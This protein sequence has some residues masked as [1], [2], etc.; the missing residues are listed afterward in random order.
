MNKKYLTLLILGVTATVYATTTS[1]LLP[2]SVGTY[3]AWTPSTGSTHYTLVDESSCNGATDYVSTTAVGSRESFGVSL[4]SIPDGA[5][6]TGLSLTPCASK[7]KNS[8]TV[9]MSLFY[10]ANGVNSADGS[11]YTLSGATPVNL[12]ATN[13]SSLSITKNASTTFEAGAVLVSGTIGARLSR[14][15]TVITYVTAPLIPTNVTSSATSTASIALGWIQSSSDQD[16]FSIEK[17]TDGTNFSLATTTPGYYRS[18][19]DTGLTAGTYYYKLRA[20]NALGYSAY[21][22][23]IVTILP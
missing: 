23:T 12:S 6:I 18:Y 7:I 20:Y 22:S 10:R 16:S 21:S 11:A 17:S 14:L 2:T 13:Y 8:G 4:S 5:L 15:A 19:I 9:T 3:S 1:S